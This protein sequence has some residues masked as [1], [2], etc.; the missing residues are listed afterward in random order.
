[1]FAGNRII[2][3]PLDWGLGHT[4][5][6]IPIIKRLI[7]L[8][9][10]PIIAADNGPLELLKAEF[11][12]LERV[13]IEG[14][15]VRYSSGN[16]Q[17]RTLAFQFPSL[18]ASIR[19]E[20]RTIKRLVKKLR[21]AAIISDQRFG[22]MDPSVPSVL[23]THQAFPQLRIGKDF[24]TRLNRHFIDRFDRCWIVDQP[25]PPGLAGALSHGSDLPRNA[26][27]IGPQSRFTQIA[28]TASQAHRIVAIISGPEPQ[29]S[30]L[31]Q[32]LIAQMD[33]IEGEHLLVNGKLDER[34]EKIGNIMIAPHLSTERLTVELVNAELIVSR[35]GYTTIM[36]LHA[37]GR[38]ALLIPTPGQPEQEYLAKLHASI[39]TFVIQQQHA[40][41]LR[42]ALTS[43]DRSMNFKMG[44]TTDLLDE[45]L[46]DL[47]EI[48]KGKPVKYLQAQ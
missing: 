4:T 27:Y 17:L 16:D 3:A 21:P 32:E 10:V 19:N 2:V 7:A 26:R 28:G 8:D 9:A 11:P 44:S 22:V 23:I 6:C 18:L 1:M 37:L 40:I 48:M 39:G 29:R 13:Q 45:A 38:S 25:E 36:D 35:C 31:E 46:M 42:T 24:A 15:P 30:I 5:R 43:I 33:M 20:R 34:S 47:A 12:E 41:D 14:S